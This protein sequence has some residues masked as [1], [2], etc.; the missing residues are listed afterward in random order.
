[1]SNRI[2]PHLFH[3]TNLVG[4]LMA[5]PMNGRYGL[6]FWTVPPYDPFEGTT[7]ASFIYLGDPPRAARHAVLNHLIRYGF[8]VEASPGGFVL[9]EEA[10]PDDPHERDVLALGR[11]I[12]SEV[13]T[14]H[15]ELAIWLAWSVRNQARDFHRSIFQMQHPWSRQLGNHPP[16]SSRVSASAEALEIARSVLAQPEDVDPTGGAITNFSPSAQDALLARGDPATHH[17][18]EWVRAKWLAEGRR[19]LGKIHG[20]EFWTKGRA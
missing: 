9:S 11:T 17:S 12:Q 6:R 16:F 10:L 5:M 15:P 8:H 20:E 18:S 13:G 7:K 14:H 19:F 3:L 4:A 2:G 1:M